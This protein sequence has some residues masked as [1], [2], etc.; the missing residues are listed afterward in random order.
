MLQI[1]GERSCLSAISTKLLSNL[2]FLIF[3]FLILLLWNFIE[4]KLRHEC[5][6]VNLLHI[7]RTTFLENTS[8]RLLLNT[9]GFSRR[10]PVLKVALLKTQSKI[11]STVLM[12]LKGFYVLSFFSGSNFYVVIFSYFWPSDPAISFWQESI[13]HKYTSFSHCFLIF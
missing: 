7:F 13:L 3:I 2:F 11:E 8:G 12:D 4:T 5:S 1:S 9:R 10:Y 6:P